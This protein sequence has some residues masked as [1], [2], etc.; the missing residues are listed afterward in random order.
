MTKMEFGR[1]AGAMILT[2]SLALS[3]PAFA[4]GGK[5]GGG[6]GGGG[7]TTNSGGGGGGGNSGGGNSSQTTVVDPTSA[8]GSVPTMD[9][10]QD[11]IGN[12]NWVTAIA[13]LKV[14]LRANPK[15]A[16]GWNL[17]G[18]SY[19]NHGDLKLSE[20]AYDHALKL[21]P[22]HINAL[23]YQGVLYVKLGQLDDA[24]AN[25]AKI[26]KIC[27]NTTCP[28]YTALSQALG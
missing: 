12:S 15:S 6:G 18:Y 16:D 26:A 24:K 10:V 27:G 3:T 4:F 28:Q 13:E 21:N 9:Q 19:R 11:E 14:Y 23:S 7:N 1:L 22:N 5:S 20:A 25:L 17:L 8:V 2:L